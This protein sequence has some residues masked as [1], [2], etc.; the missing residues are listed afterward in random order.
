MTSGRSNEC[1]SA[2]GT[3]T[4]DQ[5]PDFQRSSVLTGAVP[6]PTTPIDLLGTPARD[7]VYDV[8]LRKLVAGDLAP[9]TRLSDRELLTLT[10]S[11]RA[12]LREALSRLVH[13]GLV[14]VVPRR[15]TEV[16]P[17]DDRR[18]RESL[19]VEGELVVQAVVEAVAQPTDGD[20]SSFSPVVDGDDV[21][22]ARRDLV[23]ALLV[24]AGNREYSRIVHDLAPY[25][26][27]AL[28]LLPSLRTESLRGHLQAL[29]RAADE[30]DAEAAVA[31]WRAQEALT[32]SAFTGD[33]ARAAARR[34]PVGTEAAT[35]RDKAASAIESA[36]LD[37]TLVPGETLRESALMAWLGISRTP[38]REALLQ[39][40]GRGVVEVEHHQ[41]A[42]V[43]T[44]DEPTTLDALRALGVLRRL[45]VR[46]AMRDDPQ[47]FTA[48]MQRALDT[49][50]D[51]DDPAE[52]VATTTK[53]SAALDAAV[54]NAV[55]LGAHRL[56][57]ARLRWYASHDREITGRI[58]AA[59]VK[60]LVT[61]LAAGRTGEAE[62][63][64]W[65]LHNRLPTATRT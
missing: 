41:P 16:T 19:A 37:G 45:G 40:S 51:D 35:L 58:D 25:V 43:A 12:P 1:I 8:L 46:E 29:A 10:H 27:R 39:L 52:V 63:V 38:I 49:W 60:V 62:R 31:A 7:E 20:A 61:A 4:K 36:I 50:V 17:L 28:N 55:W 56:L 5:C 9:G 6:I 48:R 18:T 34:A 23:E 21:L 2:T 59:T 54:D 24:R 53:I 57:T 30:G 32:S 33:D 14:T 65:D 44:M 42:R 26:E 22:R 13:V 11:S 64:L 15:Y 47:G 3:N